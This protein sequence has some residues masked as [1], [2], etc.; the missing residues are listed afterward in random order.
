MASDPNVRYS[1]TS[2]LGPDTETGR[3]RAAVSAANKLPHAFNSAAHT[4]AS[5]RRL[6]KAHRPMGPRTKAR[7]F[8]RGSGHSLETGQ[9]A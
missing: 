4:L 9:L 5:Y 2:R 7:G 6:P 8:V 1:G 3:P